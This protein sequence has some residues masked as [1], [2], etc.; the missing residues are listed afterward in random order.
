VSNEF[1]ARKSRF[2]K[3]TSEIY[4]GAISEWVKSNDAKNAEHLVHLIKAGKVDVYATLDKFVSY[5]HKR[6]KAP[7][8]IGTYMSG[9]KSYLA[10]EDIEISAQ[11]FRVKVAVPKLYEISTDRI[12]TREE[13]QKLFLH[14]SLQ[15]K[16]L[17]TSLCATGLRLGEL[18]AV[19][20]SNID[21]DSKPI[22]I[23]IFAKD[24][25]TKRARFVF[26]TDEAA[27]MLKE[28][29]GERIKNKDSYVFG[30]NKPLSA[31]TAYDVLMNAVEK[32]G[33]RYKVDDDSRRYA[34]HP[35]VFRKFFMTR[36][37][38]AGLDRGVIEGM[39][40]HKFG[41]DSAYLRLTE[42]ELGQMYLKA[43]PHLTIMQSS[44]ITSEEIKDQ[45]ELGIWYLMVAS[46]LDDPHN[47][48]KNYDS[49][50]T[51]QKILALKTAMLETMREAGDN[52]DITDP[53][54]L[55]V[56]MMGVTLPI[57][58]KSNPSYSD[59]N[60]SKPYS[61]NSSIK[62][63]TVIVNANDESKLIALAN[64]GYEVAGNVNGKVLM[65]KLV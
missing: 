51:K 61:N 64:L 35:H 21:F 42:Q 54:M 24:T 57:R 4:A 26:L 60:S 39:M 13:L 25:K 49:L 53:S 41:L 59:T 43:I 9:V 2:S 22:K 62:Y 3:R 45:V 36:L 27:S 20:V 12:P 23:T 48:I 65:R 40:G 46:T 37:L 17:V 30:N 32:A 38:N 56:D 19:K 15:V 63:N 14:S 33:L 34:I 16:V 7:K 5:L 29:L 50:P 58:S 28:Y 55:T 10:F 47:V 31:S 52:L 44:D 1:L 8:T 6:G 18:L 11:K